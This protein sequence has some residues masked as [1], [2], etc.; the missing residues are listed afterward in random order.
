MEQS[1]A[2]VKRPL[3]RAEART[4]EALVAVIGQVLDAVGPTDTRDFSAHSG[5]AL[6]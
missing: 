2:K 6:P 3:R 4:F 5:F 1:S